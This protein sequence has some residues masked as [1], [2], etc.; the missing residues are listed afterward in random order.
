MKLAVVVFAAAAATLVA[1]VTLRGNAPRATQTAPVWPDAF[2]VPFNETTGIIFKDHTSGTLLVD[3]LKD[4]PLLPQDA[5]RLLSFR[6]LPSFAMHLH[7]CVPFA[8]GYFYY[9]STNSR[10]LTS[11]VSVSLACAG[12]ALLPCHTS[13]FQL[14]LQGKGD[15]YCGTVHDDD[16]PC[17]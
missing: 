1:G 7:P 13:L 3:S 17:K 4:S 12:F 2:S 14:P 11:R 10:S 9:D 6:S 15:R 5:P 16:T 8:S